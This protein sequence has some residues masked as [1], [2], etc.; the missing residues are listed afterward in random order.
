MKY[1]IISFIDL[2]ECL[3]SGTEIKITVVNDDWEYSGTSNNCVK[4]LREFGKSASRLV[5]IGN[6]VYMNNS[7]NVL[8]IEC[9]NMEDPF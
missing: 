4:E 3:N 8:E 2:L 1:P 9:Y 5:V 7:E 6:G